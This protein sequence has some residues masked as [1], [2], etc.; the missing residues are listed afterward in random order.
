MQYKGCF[1]KII[2]T[3]DEIVERIGKLAEEINSHYKSIENEE[4]YVIGVLDGSFVFCG[5]LLPLLNFEA[6]FKTVKLSLYGTKTY[7]KKENLSF[8]ANFE[9]SDIKNKRVLVLEDLLDTGL[10]LELMKEKLKK[11]YE[12][13]DVKTCVLFRKVTKNSEQGKADWVGLDIPNEWVAGFGLDSRNKYRNYKHLGVVK[14]E[15]R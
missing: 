6:I 11:E 8:E 12:A 1:S 5:H 9:K 2:Y 7:A 13:S 4:I 14:I 15:K 10:T 3:Y